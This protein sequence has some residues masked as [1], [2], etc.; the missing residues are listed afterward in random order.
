MTVSAGVQDLTIHFPQIDTWPQ[1][2]ALW[3]RFTARE[4]GDWTLPLLAAEAV[5]YTDIKAIA[6]LVQT[7]M[8]TLHL[9]LML[10]DGIMDE[11]EP[12]VI[13][14]GPG[15]AANMATALHGIG[16]ALT[17]KLPIPAE[18]KVQIT[19]MLSEMVVE[20]AVGQVADI[21]GVDNEDDYWQLVQMKSGPY[22][23]T[24]LSIG[25]IIAGSN[26]QTLHVLK[27]VGQ[28]IGM[29]IQVQDDLFDSM[30]TP[31]QTDWFGEKTN[32]LLILY[33]QQA[34]YRNKNH[35]L[36]LLPIV[37]KGDTQALKE[38]QQILIDAGAVDYCNSVLK[39]LQNKAHQHIETIPL[40]NT[41]AIL[42]VLNYIATVI[43]RIRE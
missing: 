38:V 17:Q 7:I 33:G 32:N 27:Q 16:L 23:R 42:D 13:D 4:R 29:M 11:D 25:G 3:L 9:S 34:N 43:E 21:A 18:R 2:Q 14:M 12:V 28:L 31:A 1:L 22:H 15:M 24:A 8:A 5:G 19:S 37:Q 39:E 41:T 30:S 35:F 6:P 26:T 40:I 36:E 20:M 10:T